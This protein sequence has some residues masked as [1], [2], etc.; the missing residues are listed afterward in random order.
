[1][2]FSAIFCSA[3]NYSKAIIHAIDTSY[4]D[5]KEKDVCLHKVFV[6]NQKNIYELFELKNR[7][8]EFSFVCRYLGSDSS[9]YSVFSNYGSAAGVT[10]LFYIR[11]SDVQIFESEPLYE[12][13]IPIYTSFNR[14]SH[15]IR[16]IS[17]K[18]GDCGELESKQVNEYLRQNNIVNEENLLIVFK[19]PIDI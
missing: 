10:R 14:K 5:N 13:D 16:I 2:F 19:Q 7:K 17:F 8:E 9:L 11:E 12:Y 1:M 15:F 4:H 18:N 3:Q 6:Q